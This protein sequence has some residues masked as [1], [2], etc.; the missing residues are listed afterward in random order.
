MNTSRCS[1]CGAVSHGGS[2]MGLGEFDLD[3]FPRH[4][5][6]LNCNEP[7]ED[8]DMTLIHSVLSTTGARLALLDQ[9]I[10]Q[11]R[12]RLKQ[13]EEDRTSLSSF[14]AQNNAILSPL[15]KVPAEVLSEIF[16]WTLPSTRESRQ[17]PRFLTTDSPWFLTHISRRWRA[18]AISHSSLWSLVVIRYSQ[19]VGSSIAYPLSMVETQV[20]RAQKLKIHFRGCEISD[21]RPQIEIFQFL[22]QHSSRWDELVLR[23]TSALV[24]LLATVRSR[25]PLL[26]RL[27]V[28][29][30]DPHSQTGV[31][32]IECFDIAP[33]LVDAGAYHAF[34]FI[35]ISLPV[36][37]L[38]RYEL[39][40]PWATHMGS[41]GRL[42]T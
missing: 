2:E 29:W 7:P 35:P 39:D 17:R 26:R 38:T 36:Q 21:A 6:L 31:E 28:E 3:A 9:D 5:R 23:P 30:Y 20:A 4:Q 25:V 14:H 24:P 16:L 40:C 19:E 27:W 22:A 42:E 37:Q 32:S 33:S 13:L 15:R 18:V 1:Q 41:L 11:L 34:R 8:S 12:D 10:S